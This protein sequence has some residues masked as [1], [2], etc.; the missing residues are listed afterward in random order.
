MLA[1]A[2][3]LVLAITGCAAAD[4][5]RPD[6]IYVCAQDQ[7]RIDVLDG[8][9]LAIVASISTGSG[10]MPHNV[11]STPA[12]DRILV[13]NAHMDGIEPDELLII[14][15]ASEVII[16]R[17]ALD[18]GA[19]LAH[20]VVSPD[21][22]I[23]YVSGWASDRVYRV[24]LLA[25]TR[26]PDFLMPGASSPHGMRLSG[27]GQRLYTANSRGSVTELDAQAGGALREWQLSGPAIQV[28]LGDGVV[29]AAVN[30]PA[31]VA[32]IDLATGEVTEWPFPD[33]KGFAQLALSPDGLTLYVADQG[34]AID[35]GSELLVL[36]AQ[37]G[38]LQASREVGRGAHGVAL[39]PDGRLAFVT[40]IYD[41]SVA[42]VDLDGTEQAQLG[43]TGRGPN[44]ILPW[45]ASE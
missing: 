11:T 3:V 16:T 44:G 35:P 33:A 25:G 41:A 28:A 4:P 39:S 14:D 19:F 30:Y 15:P 6:K 10:R 20:V 40:A 42:V 32:R 13:T 17:V 12:G 1:A 34:L 21:G 36:D 37:T 8:E 26:M 27:D 18:A 23:A 22:G 7:A 45:R 29:Y 38:A 31:A 2:I 9:T 24:D 5:D 43:T